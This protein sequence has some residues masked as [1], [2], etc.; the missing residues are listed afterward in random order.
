MKLSRSLRTLWVG[1]AATVLALAGSSAPAN[2]TDFGAI[3]TAVS[4]P[5]DRSGILGPFE[6]VYSFSVSTD[7]SFSS[8]VSTGDGNRSA[9]IDLAG[10]LL[11][12][13]IKVAISAGDQGNFLSDS[14]GLAV[15]I[16]AVP[17]PETL[18]LML[19]SVLMVSFIAKRRQG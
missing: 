2:D 15:T 6:D 1:L 3:G 4:L 7:P 5:I 9:V 17:E 13:G 19:A 16:A 8:F 10:A 18:A 11:D 14:T 12:A